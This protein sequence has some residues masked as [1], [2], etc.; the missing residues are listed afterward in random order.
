MSTPPRKQHWTIRLYPPA[1]RR[2]YGDEITGLIAQVRAD[3]GRRASVLEQAAVLAHALRLR[4]GTGSAQPVGRLLARLAPLVIPVASVLSLTLLA[5]WAIPPLPW[6]GPRAYTPSAYAAWPVVLVCAL[7]GRWTAAR[8][9]AACALGS[10]LLSLPLASWTAAAEGQEQNR[11]TLIGLA[12]AALLVLATPPDLPPTAAGA[13]RTMAL[14]AL[15]LGAPL[16]VGSVT[17]FEAATGPY[18]STEARADPL[19]LLFFFGPLVLAFPV[20]MAM[21]RSRAGVFLAALLTAGAVFLVSPLGLP[22]EFP[23]G[24]G[25]MVA[26]MAFLTGTGAMVRYTV[27]KNR[28]HRGTAAVG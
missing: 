5:V 18:T 19:R 24:S 21:A 7:A 27:R 23:Y 15:A 2:Q 1:H 9:A 13:R 11:A 17:V 14:I 16:L 10:A 20:A 28:R 22:V 8:I 6:D 4:T 3:E 12:L 26:S 25:G